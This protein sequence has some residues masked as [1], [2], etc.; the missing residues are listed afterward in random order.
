MATKLVST[1]GGLGT[2]LLRENLDRI[3]AAEVL[4]VLHAIEVPGPVLTSHW[5]HGGLE[6]DGVL[7]HPVDDIERKI[8]FFHGQR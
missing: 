4:V 8:T 6:E 7:V 1:G 2:G 3:L 5:V